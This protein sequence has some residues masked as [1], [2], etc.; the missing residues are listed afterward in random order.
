MPH[1]SVYENNKNNKTE[2]GKGGTTTNTVSEL[3]VA[4]GARVEQRDVVGRERLDLGGDEVAL[5]EDR[6]HVERV[7][8][9][10]AALHA[11]R[12]VHGRERERRD[13]A[14]VDLDAPALR[15]R[16]LEHA[17]HHD[18]ADLGEVAAPHRARAHELV[19]ALDRA[20][21]ARR[22]HRRAHPVHRLRH[23]RVVPAQEARLG[24]NR[25]ARHH[26]VQRRR[27]RAH[28]PR[29]L[30]ALPVAVVATRTVVS[31]NNFHRFSLFP[32]SFLRL[33]SFTHTQQ[34]EQDDEKERTKRKRQKRMK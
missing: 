3:A 18:V 1:R 16:D 30:Q 20:A 26:K 7:L 29:A 19:H 22:Q 9:G 6:A 23:V 25:L 32:V 15:R 5:L 11:A 21:H 14:R 12:E 34:E 8:L 28:L 24:R 10:A 2:W 4:R 33:Q 17:A 31:V 27:R 13:A